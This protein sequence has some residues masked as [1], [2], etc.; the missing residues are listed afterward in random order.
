MISTQQGEGKYR[1]N[2]PLEDLLD[3][4]TQRD[5]HFVRSDRGNE[6]LPDGF[7]KGDG[8]KWIDLE[9]PC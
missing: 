7:A 6:E 3:A 5:I 8:L 2:I 1:N 4:L 9:V